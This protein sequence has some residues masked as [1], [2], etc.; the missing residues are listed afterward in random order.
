M[1][2]LGQLNQLLSDFHGFHPLDGGAFTSQLLEIE[3][4]GCYRKR[5]MPIDPGQSLRLND[6]R[7]R[8][9]FSQ[10][11]ATMTFGACDHKQTAPVPVSRPMQEERCSDS[12]N[13]D[14]P[15]RNNRL[16]TEENTELA[17]PAEEDPGA[18]I[19]SSEMPFNP[20]DHPMLPEDNWS[21]GDDIRN[22]ILDA[23]WVD[24]V[25]LCRENHFA[26]AAWKT[27]GI[28]PADKREIVF[29]GL[30]SD[31]HNLLKRSVPISTMAF[32]EV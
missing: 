16:D 26:G 8:F 4:G 20:P 3:Q 32:V 25:E 28:R 12:P 14:K 21:L 10:S 31:G 6:F 29:D 9:G 27:M 17:A 1:E 24:F 11:K 18:D 15:P 30:G 19:E 7:E 13:A 22:P 2:R 23:P 5:R